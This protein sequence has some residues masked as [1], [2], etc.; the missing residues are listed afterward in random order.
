M[1]HAEPWFQFDVWYYAPNSGT[2]KHCQDPHQT[3][4]LEP[5]LQRLLNYFIHHPQQI[6]SKDQLLN[7]VW[8]AEFGTDAALMRAVAAL[9]KVLNDSVKPALYLETHPRKG[10]LWKIVLQPLVS[11][12]IL[13]IQLAEA[14]SPVIADELLVTSMTRHSLQVLNRRR[15]LAWSA[16][17]VTLCSLVFCCLLWYFE[18]VVVPEQ[19]ASH[20]P[21][22]LNIS[23]MPGAE[24]DPMMTPTEDAWL[25]W[26][27]PSGQS[28]WQ[29]IRHERAT[30]R[31]RILAH[32]FTAVGQLHWAGQ[33]LLFSAVTGKQHC[34]VFR[35][36]D[37][38]L[39]DASVTHIAQEASDLAA[40]RQAMP[41]QLNDCEYFL[42]NSLAVMNERI[43]WLEQR[44]AEIGLWTLHHDKAQ[45]LLLIKGH[46][47]LPI[48]LLAGSDQLYLLLQEHHLS[49]QLLQWSVGQT[50]ATWLADF[51]I[52]ISH[53]SWWDPQTLLISGAEQL[54][55]YRLGA[56]HFVA[57]LTPAGTLFDVKHQGETLL[58][59]MRSQGAFDL[60]PLELNGQQL[61]VHRQ[62][63]AELISNQDDWLFREEGVFVSNRSGLPQIWRSRAGQ[64]R[65]LTKFDLYK[66]VSQ[67]I[68]HQQQLFAVV[69]QQ[70]MRVALDSGALSPV[71]W[72]KPA[73]K[74][75]I[76][77]QQQW[78]WLERASRWALY[79]LQQERGQ[80]IADNIV[81]IR[82][83]PANT[84]IL[85]QDTDPH[86]LQFS[87][88]T[89][90]VTELPIRLDWRRVA[91]ELWDVRGTDLY[92]FAEQQLHHYD[93]NQQQHSVL[94]L[95]MATND[96]HQPEALYAPADSPLL[97]MLQRRSQESDIIQLAPVKP[98]D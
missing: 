1:L 79:Q 40:D 59:A 11:E 24:T 15:Y 93:F 83:G 49:Y 13:P 42:P 53:L 30:H 3:L 90:A 87:L 20:Y 94:A 80:K 64:L 66:T 73:F 21:F 92:W 7:E 58:G 70:L 8:G 10:Y 89:G 63:M 32:G 33:D 36:K 25:Y 82:C 55:R 77:C 97:F 57:L 91:T 2:L 86:L 95:P 88:E 84:L 98:L 72:A 68:W 43:Y 28:A 4:V 41:I 61:R 96:S 14:N 52:P 12:S 56:Q 34:G 35:L 5:R 9:R 65:Q 74:R 45:Q 39:S 22:Q 69:D 6:L 16:V 29:L 54:Q 85:Q 71:S 19:Q 76:S 48:Q 38:A 78:F 47:R 23:A 67:L 17:I 81:D 50:E 31:Q 60:I 51:A 62:K 18:R 44:D 26:Y 75:L 37:A 46:Y 27:Q